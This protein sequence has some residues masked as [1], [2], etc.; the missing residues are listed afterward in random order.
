MVFVDMDGVLAKWDT[1]ASLEDTYTA[2]YFA[3]REEEVR[4]TALIRMLVASGHKVAIL[5]AVYPAG[6]AAAEKHGWLDM[7]GLPDIRRIFVPYGEDKH[8]YIPELSEPMILVDDY[9]RNLHAWQQAGHIAV[10][11]YNGINGTH[12]TWKG[13]AIDH[14]M[15]AAEMF[16]VISPLDLGFMKGTERSPI[17]SCKIS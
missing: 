12:G 17:T 13:R 1:T 16:A 15:T 14:S 7:I 4:I 11:Y 6:T 2:G 10:K 9:S 3:R 5:S 8:R